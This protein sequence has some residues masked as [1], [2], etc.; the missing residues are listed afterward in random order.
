[1]LSP[2]TATVP[3]VIVGGLLVVGGI[4][5]AYMMFFNREVLDHEPGEDR[6]ALAAVAE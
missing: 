1:L 3:I 6:S 4:Y 2:A 5:F